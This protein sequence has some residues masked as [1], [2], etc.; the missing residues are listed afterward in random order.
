V[1]H[2]LAVVSVVLVALV[3]SYVASASPAAA[4]VRSS[5]AVYLVRGEHVSPVR[6]V[7]P[8]T[9]APAR[10]AIA[11][12]LRGPTA[13]ERR[14][15][16][17]SAIPGST[18]LNAVSLS[19][20]VLTVDLRR[21]FES[22]GG[23]LSMLLRVAQVVHTATQFPSVERV[24]F[25][26]D[27]TPVAAIGGEGVV[28]SPPVGRA[29]VE[30]QAPPILVEQPLPGDR[31]SAPVVVRGTANVFEAQFLVD[32]RTAAGTLLARRSVHASAGT[33]SRGSFSIRIPL[34]TSA[35]QLVVVAYDLSPKDG[36][37][38]DVV[39]VPVT[40]AAA[41]VRAPTAAL[42]NATVDRTA[43]TVDARLR[44]CF[45]SGPGAAIVVTERRTVH[46]RV[47][48]TRRWTAEGVKP[49][50]THPFSCRADWRLNWLLAPGLQGE[51]TYTATIRVRDAYGRWTS[52]VRIGAVSP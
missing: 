44:I 11:A 18:A 4:P 8:H 20:G 25:R 15:G 3:G 29:A 34:A 2:R 21:S 51:G 33:G 48:A 37:R 39:R 23:S 13:A 7:A 32:V 6:R 41:A 50:R 17:T 10:A 27:G 36:S 31:V 38:I 26:L 42:T 14:R 12:L 24:A 45:A 5:F 47:V 35:R 40:L 28:V 16:Y 49:T 30:S 1:E 43:H 19:G 46:G 52:P 22:G 9:A